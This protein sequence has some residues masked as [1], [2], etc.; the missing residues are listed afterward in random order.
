MNLTQ[1]LEATVSPDQNEL[2]QAQTY[3]EQAAQENLP[4]FIVALVNELADGGKSQVARMAAGLQLKNALA[5]KDPTIRMQ[6]Q[7]RWLT[8]DEQVKQHVKQMVIQTLGT[9]KARPAIAPQCIAAIAC[10]EIPNRQWLEVTDLLQTMVVTAGNT[11]ALKEQA[12]KSI[13][14]ICE[15]IEPEHLVEQSHKILTAIVSGMRMGKPNIQ[16]RLAAN[17]AL[18]NSFAVSKQNFEREEGRNLI[19]PLVCE[20]ALGNENQL[21]IAA[22]Q[23][24]DM[25]MSLHYPHMGDYKG[26]ALL[27]S[28]SA[29]ESKCEEVSLQGTELCSS[30]CE[31]EIDL[32]ANETAQ[33]NSQ[34]VWT[35]RS[36]V[37]A[38]LISV[39]TNT[40]KRQGEFDDKE[41]WSPCKAAALCLMVVAQCYQDDVLQYVFP[42][43]V[44]NIEREDWKS[45]DAAVIALGSILKGPHPNTLKPNVERAI[46]LLIKLMKDESVV[47][48][49]SLAW[50]L[51]RICQFLPLVALANINPLMEI[52]LEGFDAEPCLA[53]NACKALGSLMAAFIGTPVR[54]EEEILLID[55]N[56]MWYSV[57]RK[58]CVLKRRL[59]DNHLQHLKSAVEETSLV[60]R[61][62]QEDY[63]K[64]EL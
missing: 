17:K 25:I 60:C 63:L 57:T 54:L 46:P 34:P 7:Q 56:S 5:S 27:I 16:I 42:F 2:Q 47:V 49:D 59:D 32:A 15:D 37:V 48:T 9:E 62:L 18:L 55:R 52:L 31:K 39:L 41:G 8:L 58:L 19:M 64:P 61:R 12:L 33:S 1:I 6:H 50:T 13:G 51:C 30:M 4:Q 14:Y 38:E 24:L 29:I 22:L 28:L 21:K 23:N 20:A 45:R 40:L 3:L 36:H 10:A 35:S 11:D 53:V 43:I 26:A 44:A